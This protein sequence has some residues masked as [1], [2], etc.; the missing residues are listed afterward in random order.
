MTTP[1]ARQRIRDAKLAGVRNRLRDE[2]R[3][4]EP[5]AD[6]WVATW[7]SS[8]EAKALGEDAPGYWTRAWSWIL[9][10]IASGRKP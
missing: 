4:P 3:M 6:A 7:S 1:V 8:D 5:Q 2:V 9:E 10:A